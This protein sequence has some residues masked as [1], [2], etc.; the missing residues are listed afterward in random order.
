MMKIHGRIIAGTLALVLTCALMTALP[1]ASFAQKSGKEIVTT[2]IA[3]SPILVKMSHWKE[4]T[5]SQRYSFLIGFI[6]MLDLESEWQAPNPLPFKQSLTSAWM[7]GLKNK[8]LQDIYNGLN[9]YMTNNPTQLD[10]PVAE[11]MWFTFVQPTMTEKLKK[12]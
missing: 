4:S 1:S 2:K 11:V 12:R 3:D 9:E 5:P 6:T 7:R 8:S 10:R